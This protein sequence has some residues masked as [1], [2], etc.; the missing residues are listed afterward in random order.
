[1]PNFCALEEFSI[2]L[3]RTLFFVSWW[4]NRMSNSSQDDIDF[5]LKIP[6]RLEVGKFLQI[7]RFGI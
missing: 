1:M 4:Y 3:W 2:R 5:L 6:K 7:Y